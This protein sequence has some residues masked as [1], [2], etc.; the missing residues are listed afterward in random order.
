MSTETKMFYEI[1]VTSTRPGSYSYDD[2]ANHVGN[3]IKYKSVITP[4]EKQ[5]EASDRR[6]PCVTIFKKKIL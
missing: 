5:E 4:V 6:Y 1:N 3:L 2:P